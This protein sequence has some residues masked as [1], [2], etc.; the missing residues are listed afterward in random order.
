MERDPEKS[1]MAEITKTLENAGK[2]NMNRSVRNLRAMTLR[3]ETI[4]FDL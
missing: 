4:L 2:R 1:E 3:S